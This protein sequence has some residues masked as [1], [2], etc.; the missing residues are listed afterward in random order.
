MSI[1]YQHVATGLVKIEAYGGWQWVC[2]LMAGWLDLVHIITNCWNILEFI[3]QSCGHH[4]TTWVTIAKVTGASKH[5]SYIIIWDNCFY[6]QTACWFE[7]NM[8][9][10][11]FSKTISHLHR[12]LHCPNHL[13][14]L[15]VQS[16]RKLQNQETLLHLS[17]MEADTWDHTHY[18]KCGSETSAH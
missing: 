16:W 9:C 2:S 11:D 10:M 3:L 13:T 8:K 17:A 12:C 6:T 14:A 15:M 7:C 18:T 5:P 1:N 4:A